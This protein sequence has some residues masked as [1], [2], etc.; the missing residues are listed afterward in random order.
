[1]DVVL[2][3]GRVLLVLVAVSSALAV[4]F[5]KA[6]V[7]M[8]RGSGAP[9]P[10]VTVPLSGLALIVGSVMVVLGLWAD[11]GALILIAT[12]LPITYFM[13]AF[14]RFEGMDRITQ[15]AMFMKNLAIV[16]G[17]VVVFWLY[18]QGQDVDASLTDALLGR[19]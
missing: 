12:L 16:G 6:G 11:L 4:H 2:V 10:D 19:W 1:M 14:W 13:H 8:A 3:I 18:N 5:G 9:A 17:L 7:E 15:Q